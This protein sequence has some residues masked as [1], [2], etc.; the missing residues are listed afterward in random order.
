[1]KNEV[2]I[3]EVNPLLNDRRSFLKISGLTLVTTGLLLAGCSHDDNEDMPIYDTTLPGIRNGI[4]DL[5]SGDFGVFALGVYNGQ[6]LS[7]PQE[8]DNSKDV[9]MRLSHK[10]YNFKR[11]IRSV[12]MIKFFRNTD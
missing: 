12:F 2:K 1:M 9:V 10:N 5:G 3:Q 11:L 4:F 6:G 7:G 8:F